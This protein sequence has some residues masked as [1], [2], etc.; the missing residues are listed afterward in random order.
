MFEAIWSQFGT[1][2]VNLAVAIIS[3]VFGSRRGVNRERKRQS[4]ET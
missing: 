4:G 1:E 3:Y 2:I